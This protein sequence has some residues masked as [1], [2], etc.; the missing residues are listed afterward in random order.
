MAGTATH[1]EQIWTMAKEM[2]HKTVARVKDTYGHPSHYRP[3]GEVVEY[4]VEK[5]REELGER[6]SALV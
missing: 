6:L 4:R 2:G 1:S 3:R 5:H